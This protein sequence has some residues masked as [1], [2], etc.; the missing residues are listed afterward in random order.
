MARSKRARPP[1]LRSGTPNPPPSWRT[2]SALILVQALSAPAELVDERVQLRA[3]PRCEIVAKAV[4]WRLLDVGRF[5]ELE[6]HRVHA[7]RRPAVSARD[8]A[9]LETAV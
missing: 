5:R 1:I 8:I 6:L 3:Q 7:V 2:R 9:A 4:R